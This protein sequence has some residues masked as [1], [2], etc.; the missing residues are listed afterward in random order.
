MDLLFIA[1]LSI[2]MGIVL[3]AMGLSYIEQSLKPLEYNGDYFSTGGSEDY[4]QNPL[5]RLKSKYFYYRPAGWV[6]LSKGKWKEIEKNIGIKIAKAEVNGENTGYKKAITDIKDRAVT[7]QY[8]MRAASP[9]ALLGVSA[10]TPKDKIKAKYL[11]LMD[12]YKPEKFEEL[13]EAFVELAKIRQTEI[14]IAW[15]KIDH[16]IAWNE[17]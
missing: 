8:K 12:K 15:H 2:V 17:T 7:E 1:S 14:K 5:Y 4:Y 10:N 11:I 16:K 9:Y 3:V 6:I 13:D